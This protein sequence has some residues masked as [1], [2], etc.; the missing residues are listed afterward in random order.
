MT[1]DPYR[2][3]PRKPLTPKQR[4]ELFVRHSG[5]CC[6]CHNKIDGVREMWDEHI[7]PLWLDGDNS[8]E[9]R[10]PAHAR[11][12]KEKTAREAKQRHKGRRIAEKHAGAHKSKRP[13]PGSR[14]SKWKRKMNGEVVER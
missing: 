12:A 2:V 6:L 8:A 4:M 11:C 13:M 5:I 1:H 10:A 3:E 7:N 9:N 14:A